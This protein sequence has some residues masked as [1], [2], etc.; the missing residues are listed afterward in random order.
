MRNEAAERLRTRLRSNITAR[1]DLEKALATERRNTVE[2]IR[3]RIRKVPTR[4]EVPTVQSGPIGRVY[5][6][7]IFRHQALAILDEVAG[8]GS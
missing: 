2:R 1:S 3:K 4:G 8:E 7:T 5:Y 6:E